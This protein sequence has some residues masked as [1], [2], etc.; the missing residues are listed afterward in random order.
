MKLSPANLHRAYILPALALKESQLVGYLNKG[1]YLDSSTGQVFKPQTDVSGIVKDLNLMPLKVTDKK[2]SGIQQ[3]LIPFLGNNALLVQTLIDEK[4]FGHARGVSYISKKG[5]QIFGENVTGSFCDLSKK[6]E[7]NGNNS[8]VIQSNKA[9]INNASSNV[10]V[11][12]S[13]GVEIVNCSSLIVIG[14]QGMK[15]ENE[16]NKFYLDGNLYEGELNAEDLDNLF[17][18]Y[19]YSVS[20]GLEG[21]ITDEML[22]KIMEGGVVDLD[23]E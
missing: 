20:A 15:F 23:L 5:K 18:D 4:A 9:K 14:C 1:S 19:D 7:I 8:I 17:Y 12:N 6:C 10:L 16:N 13:P 3:M 2:R 22:R 21:I 11:I